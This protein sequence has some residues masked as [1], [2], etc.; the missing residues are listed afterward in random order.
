[1][2]SQSH[3][4][5]AYESNLAGPL[6]AGATSV[7][8][9]SLVG[10]DTP[11]YLVIDPD[12]PNLREWIR[13][14]AT[15]SNIIDNMDRGL[16]GSNGPGGT[17]VDHLSDAPI[18]AIFTAQLQ[19][20]IFFDINS[21]ETFDTDHLAAGNPH[22]VYLTEAEGDQF[23]LRLDGSTIIQADT[24]WGGNQLT[25][26]GDAQAD[27]DA[28]NRGQV[29]AGDAAHVADANPHVVYLLL[30]GGQMAGALDLGN[31]KI[32]SLGSPTVN[33]D[34]STK[35]YVD[36][37]ISGLPAPF[38]ALHASLTDVSE[39]Q[40]HVKFTDADARAA[41]DTTYLKLT[42]GIV[43]GEVD[44]N[45]DTDYK[46]NRLKNIGDPAVGTDA[47]SRTYANTQY[48][49]LAGGTMAGILDIQQG[50]VGAP[51]LQFDGTTTGIYYRP[52]GNVGFGFSIGG[53][54]AGDY[55][56][57]TL[58]FS[59]LDAG[60]NLGSATNPWNDLRVAT[61]NGIPIASYLN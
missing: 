30:T 7:A 38:D 41:T 11:A 56:M 28:A 22:P 1:M 55:V 9:V 58:D 57:T 39:S 24:S 29:L 52:T 60:R 26:L 20:D 18:R 21:L 4:F 23:Y 46:D 51:A 10:I 34:A 35:Q 36:D 61:I 8:V 19:D 59:S 45:A 5:N 47:M 50:S 53:G 6:L 32:T 48:L 14:L 15:T 17:G 37:E 54:A 25:N 49:R 16:E 3:T 42:G 43:S 2:S 33:S 44:F 27:G 12:D 31:F 13:V 40:H